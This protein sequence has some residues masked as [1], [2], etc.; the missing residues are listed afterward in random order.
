VVQQKTNLPYWLTIELVTKGKTTPEL[1]SWVAN[2]YLDLTGYLFYALM[3]DKMETALD[4]TKQ[5][6][7]FVRSKQLKAQFYYRRVLPRIES[8]FHLTGQFPAELAAAEA[9]LF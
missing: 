2:D 8:L 6:E 1:L 5:S 9:S 4:T 3:W 7:D